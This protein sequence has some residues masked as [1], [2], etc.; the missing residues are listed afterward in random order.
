VRHR[1]APP[2]VGAHTAEVLREAGYADA[3]IADLDRSG[4]V[5]LG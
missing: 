2:R 4:V 1:S 5:R 3:E